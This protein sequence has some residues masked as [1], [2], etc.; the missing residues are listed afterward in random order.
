VVKRQF[1][2][3]A[4]ARGFDMGWP[5]ELQAEVPLTS[6]NKWQKINAEPIAA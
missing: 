5:T 4:G 1:D 6:Q 3:I 2:N